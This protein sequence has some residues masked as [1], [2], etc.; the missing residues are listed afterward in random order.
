MGWRDVAAVSVTTNA[1]SGAPQSSYATH[2][3]R[4]F[5]EWWDKFRQKPGLNSSLAREIAWHAWCA[6]LTKMGAT[7]ATDNLP[8]QKTKPVWLC[9]C[10][11]AY[12]GAKPPV[13]D[14]AKTRL[15]S[16]FRGFDT[17]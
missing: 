7:M 9:Q 4:R 8:V 1:E 17:Q 10:G 12:D 3:T 14:P 16:Y 6:A 15:E 13:C 11:V 2:G 5:D